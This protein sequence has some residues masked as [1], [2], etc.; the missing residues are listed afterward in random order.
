MDIKHKILDT[1]EALIMRYGIKSVTMDDLAREMG[2][3]KKTLYQ[4]IPN[5]ATMIKEIFLKKI[6]EEKVIMEDIR[7]QATDAIDELMKIASYV[8]GE[9]RKFSPSIVYDLKKYYKEV[10]RLMEQ[11][12]STHQLKLMK[13]NIERGIKEG[14]YRQN[15]SADIISRL[16]IAKNAIV[17]DDELF[18]PEQCNFEALFKE[19]IKYHIYGIASPKGLAM[20]ERHLKAGEWQID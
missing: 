10:W 11:Y 6:E 20:M 16:Y 4:Y 2:M 1:T 7:L 8:I 13:A 5:K 17:A 14:L 9:L 15:M 12:H 18:P 3:S 19:H